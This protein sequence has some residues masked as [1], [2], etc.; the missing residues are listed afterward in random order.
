MGQQDSGVFER[1]MT[2]L[3]WITQT[4]V[5]VGYGDVPSVTPYERILAIF[6]MFAGVI[7]F[8]LTVGSLTSLLSDM[9]RKNS[10]YEEKVK[11][12][13][14]IVSKFQI[15]DGRLLSK[16]SMCIKCR[17]YTAEDNYQ[18]LLEVLP[19]KQSVALASIIY[20]DMVKGIKFF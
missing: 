13:D 14:Q 15:K 18:E 6:C 8:S 3:Y 7:F 16:I 19:K 10:M 20:Q 9:D 11:V 1:Y 5:T 4:V 12:L 2:S 17:V